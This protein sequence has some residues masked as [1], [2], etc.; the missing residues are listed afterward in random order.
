MGK[1]SRAARWRLRTC[2]LACAGLAA[3]TQI[4]AAAPAARL[5]DA[6]RGALQTLE[7]PPFVE[8]VYT[9][10]RSSPNRIVTEQHRVYRTQDGQER[11]D[12]IM[13]NGTAII[14]A[15]SRILRRSVWPYDV[16][17][18][19]PPADEYDSFAVP[20]ALVA[21]RRAFGFKLA[22]RTSADFMLTNLYIDPRRFLPVRETFSVTGGDCAGD[23]IINFG[24]AGKYWLPTSVQVTCT[25]QTQAGP[26]IF[27]ESIRFSN[28]GFPSSIPADVFS[29][30]GSLDAG[31]TL[32]SPP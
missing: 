1:Q 30:A 27:K 20:S 4:A 25:A 13:I 10:T 28:Y 23:G 31:G 8:Y 24:P 29:P 12:T 17:Q 5:M 11:N 7:R 2:G 19:A 26:A 21:G 18:F 9:Q 3:W 32:T 14:P 22:R 6:Y 16:A 15:V